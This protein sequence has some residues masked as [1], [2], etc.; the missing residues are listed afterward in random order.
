MTEEELVRANAAGVAEGLISPVRDFFEKLSGPFATEMGLSFG[1]WA[2][3]YRFK[4]AV[5]I[6]AKAK[7]FCLDAGIDVQSV[8][9]R[10]LLPILENG[11]VEDTDELQARWAALLANSA[12]PNTTVTILPAFPEIL[13]QLSSND[14]KFLHFLYN[15]EAL[16]KVASAPE[17]EPDFSIPRALISLGIYGQLAV[18]YGRA[19]N[20]ATQTGTSGFSINKAILP[21]F[22]LCLTNAMRLGLITTPLRA[23]SPS[24]EA[25]T[26]I[27]AQSETG[28][29]MTALGY[30]FV[31]ACTD[32]KESYS[33]ASSA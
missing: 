6:L 3:F 2:R 30:E 18:A 13:K 11:S 16:P 23:D 31:K 25:S 7:Q 22:T 26:H 32:P 28:Y 20:Q 15:T 27:R 9:P 4:N 19:T 24:G 21:E 8:P 17:V 10:L 33:S 1:D 5:K 12:D 14:V 29:Y